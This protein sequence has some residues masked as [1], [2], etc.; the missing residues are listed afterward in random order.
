MKEAVR[1]LRGSLND[2]FDVSHATGAWLSLWL[3]FAL[4]MCGDDEHAAECYAK[5]QGN[6]P[7]VPRVR[8]SKGQQRGIGQQAQNVESQ[9]RIG[10][11]QP[12]DVGLPKNITQDLCALGEG[13]STS[14]TEEAIRA[15]GQYL[16]I[17]ASRP[18]KEF[19]TGPDVLWLCDDT[20]L[21]MEVKT[22]KGQTGKYRKEDIGQLRDHVQWVKERYPATA[23]HPVFVGPTLPA[24]K[25]AN[26]G[27]DIKVVELGS[28]EGL[29]KELV[30]ALEDVARQAVPH[31]VGTALQA[32]LEERG[33]LYPRCLD[34]L[35]METLRELRR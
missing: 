5:A 10:F 4:E 21:C 13:Y 31:D 11:P 16:G 14:Q 17:E 28:F 6:Q 22:D 25:S 30:A 1:V 29:G 2:G 8:P 12:A 33:L 7:N 15:L 32:M 24:S 35:R 18:D 27:P 19:G 26:P 34:N 9:M 20:V 3:G 23:I